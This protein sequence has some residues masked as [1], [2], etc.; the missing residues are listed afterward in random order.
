VV[1]SAATAVTIS[2]MG[3]RTTWIAFVIRGV[4]AMDNGRSGIIAIAGRAE[5]DGVVTRWVIV[6]GFLPIP[7]KGISGG[8]IDLIFGPNFMT[9]W[10][11][12]LPDYS[13][14]FGCGVGGG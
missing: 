11:L 1:G 2:A 8:N 6:E 9:S 14:G 12:A 10:V 7:I 3:S 13:D 4:A 5:L